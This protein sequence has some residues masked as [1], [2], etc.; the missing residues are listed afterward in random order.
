VILANR[1][2]HALARQGRL[3]GSPAKL[4]GYGI[5]SRQGSPA[6]ASRTRWVLVTLGKNQQWFWALMK[7]RL[8]NTTGFRKN[9]PNFTDGTHSAK[10][11][12]WWKTVVTQ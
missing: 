7:S 1:R 5:S 8:R 9:F 6:M 10:S 2:R 3:V 4:Y 11:R 12:A